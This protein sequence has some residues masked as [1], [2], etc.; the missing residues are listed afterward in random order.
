MLCNDLNLQTET[1]I[2]LKDHV[3]VALRRDVYHASGPLAI[4]WVSMTQLINREI[5]ELHFRSQI[6][7]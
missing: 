7:L 3:L 2:C 5:Y 4:L 6:Y 1:Q